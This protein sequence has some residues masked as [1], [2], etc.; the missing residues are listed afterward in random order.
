MANDKDTLDSALMLRIRAEALRA[1]LKKLDTFLGRIPNRKS[2]LDRLAASLD[3]ILSAISQS[4]S[5]VYTSGN[6]LDLNQIDKV[7]QALTEVSA[8]LREAKAEVQSVQKVVTR[9]QESCYQIHDNVTK[10]LRNELGER[11]KPSSMV[12]D[13]ILKGLNQGAPDV[14]LWSKYLDEAVTGSQAIF[15][16]Y[17]D[18]LAGMALRDIGFDE[19]ISRVAEELIETYKTNKER[20]YDLVALPARQEAVA[21]TL[22]RIMRVGFP[23]WTVWALPF[24]AFEFWHVVAREDLDTELRDE[25]AKDPGIEPFDQIDDRFQNCLADAF[26]TY[27]MGPAYAYS[28]F[29]LLLNPLHAYAPQE[30]EITADSL[31]PAAALT[32]PVGDDT[33]AHA[34]LEMLRHMGSGGSAGDLPPYQGICQTLGNL[35]SSALQQTGQGPQTNRSQAD[36]QCVTLMVEAQWKL[37]EQLKCAQFNISTWNDALN[38]KLDLLQNTPLSVGQLRM[39]LNAIWSARVDPARR[40]QIDIPALADKV[41]RGIQQ[42]PTAARLREAGSAQSPNLPSQVTQFLNR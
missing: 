26:A 3:T 24:T 19:G 32:A 38:F 40:G 18:I 7:R 17:V 28:A 31:G 21:R 42:K 14:K 37:L 41:L 29:L 1:N 33:R 11:T 22:A 6:D 25:I 2:D 34:I 5:K 39:V 9:L 20:L 27:S 36:K 30:P 35:W 8:T 23:E 12:L 4:D 15:C 16:A 10:V 13:G